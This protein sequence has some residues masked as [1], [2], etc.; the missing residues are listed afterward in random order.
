MRCGEDLGFEAKRKGDERKAAV[1]IRV[2]PLPN[3]ADVR[4]T[5]LLHA[6]PTFPRRTRLSV[7]DRE[8]LTAALASL[9]ERLPTKKQCDSW[10]LVWTN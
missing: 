1:A 2:P 8:M 3:N 9:L 7:R 10:R 6:A 4:P 5:V